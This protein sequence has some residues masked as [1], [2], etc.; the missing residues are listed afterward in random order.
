[1]SCGSDAVGAACLLPPVE[2]T[3]VHMLVQIAIGQCKHFSMIRKLFQHFCACS[4]CCSCGDH[5]RV[6]GLRPARLQSLLSALCPIV[7]E[8]PGGNQPSRARETAA[9]AAHPCV[10]AAQSSN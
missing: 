5:A 10:T 8:G 3:L 4:E 1:M 6:G 7:R 2:V 9:G